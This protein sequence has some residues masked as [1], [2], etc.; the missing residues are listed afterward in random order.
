MKILL[1]PLI[2]CNWIYSNLHLNKLIVVF[3]LF[4]E[5]VCKYVKVLN[6]FSKGKSTN[7]PKFIENT[8]TMG[9]GI[10]A[11]VLF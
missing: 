7:I 11:I 4:I 10:D 9:R 5:R 6:S 2:S 1:L 3:A 8:A